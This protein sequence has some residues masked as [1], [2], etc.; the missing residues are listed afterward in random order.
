MQ[1]N[2]NQSIDYNLLLQS[3]AAGTISVDQMNHILNTIARTEER[4]SH[5]NGQSGRSGE[6]LQG[7]SDPNLR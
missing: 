7:G 5:S 3:V 2:N 4:L 6:P 1:T